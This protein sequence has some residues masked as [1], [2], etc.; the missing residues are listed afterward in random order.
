MYREE[1]V[2][3]MSRLRGTEKRSR[4]RSWRARGNTLINIHLDP[5]AKVE[6]LARPALVVRQSARDN[7]SGQGEG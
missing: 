5:R 4:Q 3:I 6:G 1:Q 2:K 7:R